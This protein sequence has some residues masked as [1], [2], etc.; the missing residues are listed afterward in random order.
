MYF[1]FLRDLSIL[2]P[3]PAVFDHLEPISLSS[4]KKLFTSV[5]QFG[6]PCDVVHLLKEVFTTVGPSIL[7]VINDNLT[8]S[9]AKQ[10]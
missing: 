7:N 5:K 8:S 2:V 9:G 4:L 6:F 1:S 3:C 10:F